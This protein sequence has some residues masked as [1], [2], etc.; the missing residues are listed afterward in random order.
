MVHGWSAETD[1]DREFAVTDIQAVDQRRSRTPFAPTPENTPSAIH[2][3]RDASGE[4]AVSEGGS[5][6]TA[7]GDKAAEVDV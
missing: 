4:H 6:L 1:T 7:V 3:G 2:T 5:K